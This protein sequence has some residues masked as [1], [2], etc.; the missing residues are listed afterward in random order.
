MAD[1]PSLG[2]LALPLSWRASSPSSVAPRSQRLELLIL[3]YLWGHY[4]WHTEEM[5][6]DSKSSVFELEGSKIRDAQSLSRLYLVL[7][8]ALLYATQQ[9]LT[10]QV[11][12]LRTQVD[13]HWRRGLSYLKI[14]LR[15]LSGFMAKGRKLLA[16]A[17]LPAADPEPC[18]S[19]SHSQASLEKQL[20]FKRVRTF[21]CLCN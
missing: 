18:Y 1:L 5:F 14:G 9:G 16:L 10:V 20:S 19:S 13:P 2:I 6:L 7:A 4:R 11:E 12:G 15:W 3:L 8:I 21:Q 17:P